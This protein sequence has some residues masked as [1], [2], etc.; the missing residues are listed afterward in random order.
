MD[1]CS[2]QF[3]A[4]HMKS[5]DTQIRVDCLISWTSRGK[6]ATYEA[7]YTMYQTEKD[8]FYRHHSTETLIDPFLL[9]QTFDYHQEQYKQKTPTRL[10][11][12]SLQTDS[13]IYNEPV[14]HKIKIEMFQCPRSYN[15]FFRTVLVHIIRNIAG[16][17]LSIQH[18]HRWSFSGPGGAGRREGRER[19]RAVLAAAARGEDGAE[20]G[21]SP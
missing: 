5:A 10:L 14:N 17:S 13:G 18:T 8:H 3:K 7:A 19:S 2:L 9:T 1:T 16:V 6:Q 4:K 20:P 21:L 11:C 12:F 15:S